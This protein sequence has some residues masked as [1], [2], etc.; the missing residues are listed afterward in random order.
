MNFEAF[1]VYDVGDSNLNLKARFRSQGGSDPPKKNIIFNNILQFL[2]FL[3]C[4]KFYT[5]RNVHLY[6]E[7]DVF[8]WI[9]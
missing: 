1:D 7:I 2:Y 6:E 8:F 9:I 4:K 3:C 5:K